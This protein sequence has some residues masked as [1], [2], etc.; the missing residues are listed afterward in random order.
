MGRIEQLLD[1]SVAADEYLIPA[2]DADALFDLAAV[3]WDNVQEAFQKGRPRTAAQ[4]LRSL[5]SA[6]L[7]ALVRLNP[8]RVDLVERFEKLVADYNAGSVNTEA[9]FQ[10]LM[11]FKQ[12]LSDE[13]ARAVREEMT[14]EQLA[15]FD[16]IMRP[17]PELTDAEKDQVKRVA[18]ELLATLKRG[19]SSSTG[20]RSNSCGRRCG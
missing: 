7:A 9:F 18:E 17:A 14:E 3:D 20:A 6:K 5:L 19:S 10:Q 8:A 13:E 1:E 16:L 4:R 15:V 12:T 11:E 2:A